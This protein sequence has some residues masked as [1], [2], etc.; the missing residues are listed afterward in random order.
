[1]A[2]GLLLTLQVLQSFGNRVLVLAALLQ[3]RFTGGEKG[4]H[5]HCGGGNL[6]A[7]LLAVEFPIAVLVL[8]FRNPGKCQRDRLFGFIGIVCP[9]SPIV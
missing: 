6:L 9:P 2:G 4:E 1:L 7:L 5:S 8:L 3:M